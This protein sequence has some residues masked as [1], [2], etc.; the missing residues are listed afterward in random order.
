M[1]NSLSALD[2]F[3]A[4]LAY[5]ITPEDLAAA[6]ASDTPPTVVDT[7]SASAW[8]RGRIPGALHILCEN[9]ADCDPG[10]LPDEDADI[11]VYSWGS[12]DQGGIRAAVALLQLGYSPV[13]ELVGGFSAWEDAGLDVESDPSQAR[14]M[15]T[16]IG[17]PK[18]G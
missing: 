18:A 13:R 16:P 3:S 1:K 9:L 17:A 2:F 5:E 12:E 4:K 8:R 10:L 14:H 15:V 11:V 7:R 6:Q